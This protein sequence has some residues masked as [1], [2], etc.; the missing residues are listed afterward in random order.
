MY[1]THSSFVSRGV[2]YFCFRQWLAYGLGLNRTLQRINLRDNPIG[3]GGGITIALAM[4]GRLGIDTG[5]K[6]VEDER[7]YVLFR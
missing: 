5:K 1:T 2:I 3:D 4:Q 7:T 6:Y